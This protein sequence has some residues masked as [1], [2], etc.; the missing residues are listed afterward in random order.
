MW[1]ATVEKWG[2]KVRQ[3]REYFIG[4]VPRFLIQHTPVLLMQPLG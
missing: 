1:H 3:E 4:T 2:H